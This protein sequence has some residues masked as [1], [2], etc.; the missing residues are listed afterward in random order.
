MR[1]RQVVVKQV[2]RFVT[3]CL[4][5]KDINKIL[6]KYSQIYI[7]QSCLGLRKNDR[8]YKVCCSGFSVP[9]HNYSH[10]TVPGRHFYCKK[11]L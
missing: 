6:L 7:Q 3:Y 10:I 9:V 2:Q 4:I 8:L 5:S 1:Q 11:C